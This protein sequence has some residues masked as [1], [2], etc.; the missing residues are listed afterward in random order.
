M[1]REELGILGP[2][3]SPTI[4]LSALPHEILAMPR[5]LFL[6]RA[7]HLNEEAIRKFRTPISESL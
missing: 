2:V 4:R 5:R 6:I 7:I 3:R 1:L